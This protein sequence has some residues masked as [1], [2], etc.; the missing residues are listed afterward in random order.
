MVKALVIASLAWPMLLG[1][2]AWRSATAAGGPSWSAV[3]Y[4]AA[5]RICH[6]RPERSFHTGGVQW[7]VCARCSGLYLA[8]PIGACAAA[9]TL[10]R[11]RAGRSERAVRWLLVAAVPT[12]VTLGA[13]WLGLAAPGNLV[14]AL[15]ALPLGAMLA[16]VLV[17]TAAGPP[18]R[19]E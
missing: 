11:R 12:A 17:Q 8:A 15:A 6:Q 19:I 2:A 4:V 5:S 16:V 9:L 3:V 10:R 14:R 7:P 18:K 13:E 1:A